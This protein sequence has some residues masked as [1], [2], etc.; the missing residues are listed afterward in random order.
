M[1]VTGNRAM[2]S[3]CNILVA[4]RNRH[5]REFLRRELEGEGYRVKMARDGREVWEAMTGGDPPH[6]L[7]LDLEIPYVEELV[8]KIQRSYSA[9]PV[10]LIVHSFREKIADESW[11]AHA[12]AFLE[13]RE[14]PAHLKE[15]V[16]EVLARHYRDRFG[17]LSR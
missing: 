8:D 12:A 15:V 2:G 5:V 14:D 11:L 4:D 17:Y 13:K 1:I 6:L 16:A 9:P 3:D 10:P 7:I